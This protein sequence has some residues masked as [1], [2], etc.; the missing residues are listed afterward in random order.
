MNPET[1]NAA[2]G[3]Q[4]GTRR[5]NGAMQGTTKGGRAWTASVIK[6]RGMRVVSVTVA[7]AEGYGIDAQWDYSPRKRNPASP[8]LATFQA[9]ADDAERRYT[10]KQASA[11]AFLEMLDDA[12]HA[13]FVSPPPCDHKWSA[14]H[15]GPDLLD[16]SSDTSMRQRECVKCGTVR[17]LPPVAR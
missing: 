15:D 12:E 11:A 8:D 1:K 6:R 17:Q 5:P 13:A 2:Q 10:E 14:D 16:T 3:T 9:F 7:G 4:A